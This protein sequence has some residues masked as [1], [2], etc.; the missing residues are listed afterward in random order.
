VRE[1]LRMLKQYCK[2]P[3]GT[4]STYTPAVGGKQVLWKSDAVCGVHAVFDVWRSIEGY[5]AE[6]GGDEIKPPVMVNY[7][8]GGLGHSQMGSALLI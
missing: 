3:R 7:A 1:S 8:A 4:G 5:F 2:A 6:R